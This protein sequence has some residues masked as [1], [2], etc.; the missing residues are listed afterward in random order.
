MPTKSIF[1]S[2]T[3]WLNIIETAVMVLPQVSR[4]IPQP[5]GSVVFGIINVANR[6]FTSGEVTVP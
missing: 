2:K 4:F 1:A 6:F 5:W 3:F